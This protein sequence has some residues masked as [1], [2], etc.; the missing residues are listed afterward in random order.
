[1]IKE[2]LK[3]GGVYLPQLKAYFQQPE[4]TISISLGLGECTATV[5]GCD[6]SYE[7]VRVNGEYTT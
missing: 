4:V 6:L 3:K 7:Y 2:K 5:W 1:L